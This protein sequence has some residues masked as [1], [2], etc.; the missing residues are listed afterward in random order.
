[1]FGYFIFIIRCLF[2]KFKFFKLSP[3]KKAHFLRNCG[4][5]FEAGRIYAKKGAYDHAIFCF[6][7][8]DAYRHLMH[9][10]E[11][12]GLISEAV[13]IAHAH[14]L[15]KE[16]AAL[17]MRH[18]HLPKAAYFYH[19]F[20]IPQAIKLYKKLGNYSELG[21]CYLYNKRPTLALDAFC[22]C[23]DPLEKLQGMRQVEEAAIVLYLSKRYKDATKLFLALGD[24]Y[25]VLECAKKRRDL[26]LI[27]QT[28]RT[29]S[30]QLFQQGNLTEASRLISPFD[31]HLARLY[32]YLHT[33][34]NEQLNMAFYNGDYFFILKHC[35]A[36]N[37][38]LLA[39]EIRNHWLHQTLHTELLSA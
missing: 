27:E 39:K 1:M 26:P 14:Q 34:H 13:S 31:H 36:T 15:Y 22:K 32:K 5:Y 38:L 25:S 19:F 11:K 8:C 21:L 18:Q 17:C 7:Q 30:L 10:Y 12:V 20:D 28:S 3:L 23:E 33:L 29:L 24:Y 2:S 4:L 6:A 37:N 9:C 35:F 16:G